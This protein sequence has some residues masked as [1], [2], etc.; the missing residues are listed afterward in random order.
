MSLPHQKRIPLFSF[1][2]FPAQT[3]GR[4]GTW[5]ALL[6]LWWPPPPNPRE[7]PTQLRQAPPMIKKGGPIIK[8]PL[9]PFGKFPCPNQW[10]K[11]DLAC[12]AA[13]V[14]APSIRSKLEP[15]PAQAS[16]THDQEGAPI[17]RIPLLPFGKFPCPNQWEEGA[18]SC[19]AV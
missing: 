13:P 7:N 15:K 9:L 12:L 6:P 16:P 4:R 18:L 2:E 17:I 1:Q 8:I 14:V 3:S 5:H 11:G 19:L 10:E